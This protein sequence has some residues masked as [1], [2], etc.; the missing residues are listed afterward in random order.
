[1]WRK[2][3]LLVAIAIMGT[4]ITRCSHHN[5]YL[6]VVNLRQNLEQMIKSSGEFNTARWD[7]N[8]VNFPITDSKNSGKL[9]IQIVIKTFKKMMADSVVKELE[10]E[11][12]RPA[13]LPELLA[14][15]AQ[16]PNLQKRY[17]II[18]LGSTWDP[19]SMHDDC[20]E[21]TAPFI[22]YDQTTTSDS[23]RS[24]GLFWLNH[25]KWN[26]QLW[27]RISFAAVKVK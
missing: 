9:K 7:I 1:M 27:R 21:P 8:Q 11:G 25:D 24:L 22:Y 20:P 16:Y 5:T 10:K 18:A 14:L 15:A 26:C 2:V 12:L 17:G 3:L 23:P 13:T 4:A 19:N 6:V